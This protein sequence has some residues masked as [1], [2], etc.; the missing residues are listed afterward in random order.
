[1][2]LIYSDS[3]LTFVNIFRKGW[4]HSPGAAIYLEQLKLGA[5]VKLVTA[6]AAGV[7]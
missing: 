2:F 3:L 7:F 1:M 6:G 4:K 5:L